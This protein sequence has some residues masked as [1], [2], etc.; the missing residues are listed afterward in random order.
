[1]KP[2]VKPLPTKIKA[3]RGTLRKHRTNTQEPTAQPGMPACPT[4]LAA[5]AKREWKRISKHL[6]AM[7]LLTTID[8]AALA[9]YCDAYGRWLDAIQALQQYGV[10]I[11][12]PNGYP[13]QSPYVA[14]ANKAGEQVRLLLA[15]FGMSPASRTRV[16]AVEAQR[17]PDEL[18]LW[19]TRGG[20]S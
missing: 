5:V 17:E 11:K 15:E 10:V 18:E 9:L 7:G 4:E 2:G 19:R 16:T 20:S 3:L 12:S 6:S 13:V 8:R 1:M 14:I